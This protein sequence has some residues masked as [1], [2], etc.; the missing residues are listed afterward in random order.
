MIA[1]REGTNLP[2]LVPRRRFRNLIARFRDTLGFYRWLHR[3]YG[4]IVRYKI[5]VYEFCI[6][7]K[8]ELIDEVLY[9]NRSSFVKGFLYK[10]GLVLRRPTVI[11]ADGWEHQRRRRLVQPYFHRKLLSA[12]SSIMAEEAVAMRDS[13][14]DGETFDI[15]EAAHA[16]TLSISLRIFFGGELQIDT[17]MLRRV[18]NLFMIDIGLSMLMGRPLRAMILRACR[19]HQYAYRKL[20]EQVATLV[21]AAREDD[22]ERTDLIS[23]L[24]RATDEEGQYAHTV[25]EVGDGA[26]EM[27]VSS[28]STT[29]VTIT[30]ATYYLSQNP[31]ARERLERE[32]DE[33]LAGPFPTFED[34]E[35]LQYTNAVIDETL[36]LAPPAYYIGRRATQDVIIG[37]FFIPAGSNV[38]MFYYLAQRDERYFPEA[39]S[40][41]PERWLE[42]QPERPR[43]SYMPF[44]SGTRFCAGEAFARV[45][46]AFALASIA[47]R[48]RLETLSQGPPALRT[49]AFLDFKNGLSVRAIRR[50]NA[51]APTT[52]TSDQPVDPTTE[53]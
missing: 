47:Q 9:A 7:S 35:S 39:D 50:G 30:W 29:A 8:A 11:T 2:P 33:A 3:K 49:F 12:Y 18:F 10:R 14:R 43:C 1:E 4:P 26:L 31:V 22:T 52:G 21:E 17:V 23:Y 44:G 5:L 16:V 48:W 15:Y 25:E 6:L 53:R 27:L 46:L 45:N 37:D 42:T 13:W 32:V 19:P 28:L 40:F 38:Q 24:A 36:R 41:R 51:Q 20:N 34:F